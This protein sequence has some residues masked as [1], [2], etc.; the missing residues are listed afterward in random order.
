[1][2]HLPETSGL[3]NRQIMYDALVNK[4]S[5]FEGIFVAAIKTTGIF[6]RP[7]CTAR[8]PKSEN[9]EYFH[10]SSEALLHGYRPCRICN[11]LKYNGEIPDW[12]KEIFYE[13]DKHP[14]MRLHD[15][16]LVRKGIDPN[17]IRRWFKKHYGMTFHA[18]LRTLRLARAYGRIRQGDKVIEAAYDSGYESLSGF[19]H[20]F[21]KNTGFS[22]MNSQKKDIIKYVRILSPL[23]P[24]VAGANT[25]GICLLEFADRP[26]LETQLN[27]IKKR[28]DAEVIPGEST[29][30][31]ALQLQLEKYFEGSLQKFTIPLEMSGTPFQERVWRSL[32][33]IPYGETRSY[34][35]IAEKIGRP[36]AVRAVARA[37]GDNRIAI[38]IPCHR[39]IGA[40]GKMV[41]YGGGLWR[42]KFLLDLESGIKKA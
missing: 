40:D 23:G 14:D 13:I 11:P 42:K 24:L 4:D 18:F 30:L 25:R 22:P 41:G 20:S 39:V 1:M 31:D 12:M 8:K 32:L 19:T 27:R 26:M 28:F 3:P 2:N 6:C 33:Q 36:S 21:R 38:I 9:V 34:S 35:G 15:R 16:D 17:R 29:F 10:N 5:S 37:N 7:T